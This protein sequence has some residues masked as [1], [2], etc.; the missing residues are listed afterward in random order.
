[1]PHELEVLYES[2]LTAGAIL[3]GFCGTFLAFHLQRE[4]SYYRQPAVDFTTA[5]AK[6]IDIDLTHF[7]SGLFLLLLASAIVSIFGIVVPLLALTGVK[8]F[9]DRSNW[10]V[11]G[12]LSGLVILAM[13]FAVELFHYRVFRINLTN[14]WPEWKRE[15]PFVVSGLILV[16]IVVLLVLKFVELPQV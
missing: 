13:Y 15:L 11:A 12:V 3:A 7:T 1:M 14:D 2:L 8:W 16:C 6:D 5:K 9:W 4:A 10:A